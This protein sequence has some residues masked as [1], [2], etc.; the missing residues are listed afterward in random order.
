MSG[1]AEHQH[2]SA[3]GGAAT[4]AAGGA[5]TSAAIS[6]TSAAGGDSRPP[7]RWH[8]RRNG[9]KLSPYWPVA[10]AEVIIAVVLGLFLPDFEADLHWSDG[11]SYDTS[12]AQSTLTAIAGGMFTLTGFVLTAVTLIVQSQSSRLLQSLNRTDK[13]PLLFGTFIATFMFALIVLGAVSSDQVPSISVTVALVLVLVCV[14]LFLRLLVTF[15]RSL[16]VSGLVRTIGHNL[17]RIVD[18]MYPAPFDAATTPECQPPRET[19]DWTVRHAGNP[20][21]FESFSERAAVRLATRTGAL[22]RFV[23]AVGEFLVTGAVLAVGTGPEPPPARLRRLVRIQAER[24][25]EQDPAYGIR[26]L[27]DIA[28]RAL[29]PAVNDPTSAVQA[30][31]QISDILHRLATRSLGDGSLHDKGGRP[32][33]WYTAPTWQSYLDLATDEIMDYGKTSIQVTG[34]MRKMLGD[35]LTVIPPPRR[36]AVAAKLAALGARPGRPQR[37]VKSMIQFV[38]QLLPSSVEKA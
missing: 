26:I 10:V 14:A 31:D 13:S 32:V 27:V 33:V 8:R 12:T 15:R 37:R 25:L 16:T 9:R 17:R 7:R 24:T 23:P 35:L 4:S 34:A 18:V 19:P 1:S 29:S 38:S 6:A 30:L 22:I 11:L 36:E 21:L 5:A 2:T 28:I 3:A 20:G